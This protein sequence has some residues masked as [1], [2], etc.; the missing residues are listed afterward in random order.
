MTVLTVLEGLILAAGVIASAAAGNYTAAA[1]A[2]CA[3]LFLW[4]AEVKE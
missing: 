1:F 2:L 3:L 4:A